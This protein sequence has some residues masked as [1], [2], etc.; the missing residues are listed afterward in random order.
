MASEE[1]ERFDH[2]LAADDPR[3][4]FVESHD[5][6][7]WNAENDGLLGMNLCFD[8]DTTTIRHD[9]VEAQ[10]AI[11]TDADGPTLILGNSFT[12]DWEVAVEM[13]PAAAERL[14]NQLQLAADLARDGRD[15]DVR[16]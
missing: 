11:H 12:D 9:D 16:T 4:K 7:D 8:T 15:A 5:L 6:V 13:T 2:N 10:A 3:R 1:S 14:G